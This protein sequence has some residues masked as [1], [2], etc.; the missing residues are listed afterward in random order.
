MPVRSLQLTGAGGHPGF[1]HLGKLPYLRIERRVL[2]GHRRVVCR[3][4]LQLGVRPLELH[5]HLIDRGG[6]GADL[7]IDCDGDAHGEMPTA[8]ALGGGQ[9]PDGSEDHAA[10]GRAQGQRHAHNRQQRHQ[11]LLVAVPE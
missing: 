2:G 7:V 11:R 1:Q 5:R 10:H 8:D 4:L 3:L 6:E 9:I